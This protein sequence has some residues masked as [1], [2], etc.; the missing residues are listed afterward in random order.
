MVMMSNGKYIMMSMTIICNDVDAL[1]VAAAAA[2]YNYIII[3]II[4]I[5]IIIITIMII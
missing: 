1:N 3:I 2:K 5:T 4:I